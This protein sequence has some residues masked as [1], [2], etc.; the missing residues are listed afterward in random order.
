MCVVNDFTALN[1]D[2]YKYDVYINYM[3]D[4]Q[5]KDKNEY[6]CHYSYFLKIWREC[7][8]MLKLRRVSGF[9]HC[10]FCEEKKEPTFKEVENLQRQLTERGKIMARSRNGL[11]AQHQ[12]DLTTQVKYARHLALLGFTSRD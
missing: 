3:I 9:T 2:A 6:K 12:R 1:P 11:C 7:F 8:P 10:D 5:K 4:L